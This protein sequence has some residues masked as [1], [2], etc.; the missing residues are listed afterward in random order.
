MPVV[1]RVNGETIQATDLTGKYI[2]ATTPVYPLHF[3][4]IGVRLLGTHTHSEQYC[5]RCSYLCILHTDQVPDDTT[6]VDLTLADAYKEAA[7][8]LVCKTY[9]AIPPDFPLW[10]RL[11]EKYC[12]GDYSEV[13]IYADVVKDA[14]THLLFNYQRLTPGSNQPELLSDYGDY[15]AK[16]ICDDRRDEWPNAIHVKAAVFNAEVEKRTRCYDCGTRKNVGYISFHRL[17]S[18]IDCLPGE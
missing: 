1:T 5:S 17:W 16:H 6:P 14:G 11:L 13:E 7:T 4:V 3:T 9:L 2:D 18:C 15:S 12:K 8:C 10:N